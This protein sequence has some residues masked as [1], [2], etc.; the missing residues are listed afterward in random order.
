MEFE[1]LKKLVS[2]RSPFG[3]ENEISNF[4]ASFLEER[5]FDVEL[6]PVEG[7]GDDVMAR[8]PGKGVTVVLNGHMD[9]V[10][11]SSGWRRNPWGELD[12]DRFYGLGSVDMKAG[13]AAL[14][15]AFVE[16]GELPK[17]ERPEIIFTAVSDEEGYSRGAWELIKSGK[18][19]GADLVLL[20][21]PTN[22]K[23]MLG[24]RGRFVVEVEV[25]GKKAHAA[26][27]EFGINAVE[28]VGKLVGNLD[29]IR[30]RSHAKLG[31]GSYCTLH[32]EGS[33][34]GLSV[35][36]RARAII[37]RHTVAGEDWE[38]VRSELLTLSEKLKLKG[39]V[40]V[41]KFARPTPEMLPYVVRENTRFVRLFR[42]VCAETLGK[43]P[44]V[45]YGR[46]VGDFNYFA[47]Y[48]GKPTIV[49]G[50]VGGNWHARDEWV[51]VS[52]VRGVKE[53]YLTFLK[54]LV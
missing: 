50:P 43:P 8:L 1:L 19:D 22:E 39:E 2:I 32:V 20:A 10:N 17:R 21:E 4:I 42:K 41:S 23:L 34:D 12:G 27:P 16:M 18:L 35:P 37:D 46:S 15:A 24:A 38:R 26:R 5:G 33:A 40:R 28:E 47:T 53:T 13:L 49:F 51:S 29:R 48:L 14:I 30:L 6:L 11:L 44:E 45:T 36:D 31:K 3:N 25:I 52:S 54:S 9:T 7:F